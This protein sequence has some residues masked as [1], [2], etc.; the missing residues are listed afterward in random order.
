[1]TEYSHSESMA[2]RALDQ[3]GQEAL[4]GLAP[5]WEQQVKPVEPPDLEDPKPG[6]R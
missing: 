6:I 5:A 4:L 1:M 2:I 3:D